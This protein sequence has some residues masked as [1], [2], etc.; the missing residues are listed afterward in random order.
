MKNYFF[1]L[2]ISSNLI[3]QIQKKDTLYFSYDEKYILFS[4][5]NDTENINY[6]NF[7]QKVVENIK[8][9]GTEGYFYLTSIDTLYNLNPKKIYS[10]KGYV[11]QRKFYYPG[12]Y[13]RTVNR[14]ILKE[15]LF[16]KYV[17]FIVD[18][19][20]FIKI[21][22]HPYENIYN[23]YYPIK[24]S[25]DKIITKPLRDTVFIKFDKNILTR[26]QE[27]NGKNYFYL[28]KNLDQDSGTTYFSEQQE[29]L[30]I[31]PTEILNLRELIEK[32]G[33]YYGKDKFD[34]FDLFNYFSQA[35]Y[36]IFIVRENKYFKVKPIFEIE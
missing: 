23:S 9:T 34:D 15:N 14:K 5:D 24:F 8:W 11:E 18:D 33:A 16:N 26:K 1:I 7:E 2:L 31:E 12:K 3:A 29:Y 32:S 19:N 10:L 21:R 36:V 30:N 20:N 25:D 22:Q 17:I 35:G 4:D 27:V 6:K 13:S 28:I